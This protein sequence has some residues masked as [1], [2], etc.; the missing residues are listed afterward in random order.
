MAHKAYET[1]S[2]AGVARQVKKKI[3]LFLLDV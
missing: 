1:Y 3:E 2:L